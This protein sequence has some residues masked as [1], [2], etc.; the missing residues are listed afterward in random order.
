MVT[1]ERLASLLRD[2][3]PSL[4]DR[5]VGVRLGQPS[6]PQNFD[7][8][9][10]LA[11]KP[12]PNVMTM[13]MLPL[14]ATFSRR[15]DLYGFDGRAANET[16]F[17]RHGATT[18]FDRELDEIRWVH[19]GFFELDYDDYY[20]EHVNAVEQM[21][22]DLEV[23]G[24]DVIPRTQSR[25]LPLR[26]RM[27]SVHPPRHR[28]PHPPPVRSTIISVTP[29]WTGSFGHYGPWERAVSRRDRGWLL[30]LLAGEPGDRPVE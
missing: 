19:P 23:R 11:V 9:S 24:I 7:L 15:I 2:R 26:R 25:M 21:F 20:D 12:Y 29:D 22:V 5:I 13:L 16:Y 4:R 27:Q 17:W 6:W 1:V 10:E 8:L 14:A 3:L 28:V 30:V 18:Q